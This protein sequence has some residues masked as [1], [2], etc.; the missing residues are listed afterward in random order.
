[1]IRIEELIATVSVQPQPGTVP[2]ASAGPPGA[3]ASSLGN[4]DAL[5]SV[6]HGFMCRGA[7]RT[8]LGCHNV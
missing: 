4:S 8:P 1:V 2:V 5:L 6:W 3:V 7:R